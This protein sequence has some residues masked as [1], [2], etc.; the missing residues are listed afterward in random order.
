MSAI[1]AI[2]LKQTDK[3]RPT[4]LERSYILKN[5]KQRFGYESGTYQ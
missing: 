1:F 2:L 5:Y 4:G 3:F